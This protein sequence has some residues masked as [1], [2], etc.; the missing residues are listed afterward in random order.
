MYSK[1]ISKFNNVIN[2]QKFYFYYPY[3]KKI[4]KLISL[5]TKECLI[6]SYQLNNNEIKINLI[7]INNKHLIQKMVY[8]S[9]NKN[10]NFK[11]S[12]F[13][14]SHF[15]FIFIILTNKGLMTNIQAKKRNINGKLVCKILC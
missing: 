15:K 2:K 12:I 11:K 10:L 14:L 9:K 5:L 7:N 1:F 3:S 13:N 4:L 8:L 6:Q